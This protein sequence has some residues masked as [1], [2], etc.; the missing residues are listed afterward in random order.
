LEKAT[1]RPSPMARRQSAWGTTGNGADENGAPTILQRAWAIAQRALPRGALILSSLT[2]VNFAVGLLET[3][4]IAHVYGAG[5]ESSA[6][7]A[8]FALPA[9]ILDILVVGGLIASFVPL[10]VG[11]R[12]EEERLA[13][14]FARTILTLALLV[15]AALVAVMIVFAPE[16]VSITAPGFNG[17]QRDLTINLF[18]LLAGTQILMAAV[19]VLGEIL[20]AEKR[21]LSYAVAPITYS[22]GIIVGALLLG[23]DGQLGI[24]GAA[25]GAFGG[26]L[27]YAAIR[28]GGVL[29]AGVVPWPRLS[30]RTRGLRQY[31]VL[32]GPKMV[33]QPLEGTL[34]TFYFT[35]L[36]SQLAT[37]AV[38]NLTFARKFQTAPELIIGA[39]FAIAAFPAL[40]AAA[41]AGDW[42]GF[43][44][45]FG[46][47][48]ATI[49]VL[50]TGAALSLLAL[51]WLAV[52]I[53]LSGGA[54]TAQDVATTTMLV[55]I[56]A[57]SI[58]LESVV[59]LL[60]RAIYAT[61][62]TFLPMVASWV[63]FI[64]LVLTAQ[65]LAP[66]AGLAAIPAAYGVGMGVRVLILA[67]ALAPR[68][69]AIGRPRMVYHP[70][71]V[72]PVGEG[73]ETAWSRP[74]SPVRP[75]PVQ[76]RPA[77]YDRRR[78]PR[79]AAA[80][81][82][83]AILLVGGAYATGQAI[84]GAS[85]FAPVTTPWAR[86]RPPAAVVTSA[87][88]S[89][90]AP[91]TWA[92]TIAPVGG[93]TPTPSPP[94]QFAM[95]LYQPGDFVGE[96]TNTWCMA[97]AM[98]TMMNIMDAG[99]DTS[100]DTQAKL[101]SLAVSIAENRGGGPL[102]Q[103]W[104]TGL[105]QLGYGKYQVAVQNRM[106]GA[107]KQAV[108]QIRLTNRP[109]GLLVWY[110]WHS[111]VVSGFVATADPAV[112]NQ[113]SVISLSIEDVWYNR[114]SKLWNKDRNG[115]SRPPD[116]EVPYGELAVDFKKWDQAVVYPDYQNRY[117]I[118]VPVK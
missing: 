39:Q 104:A 32:M 37:G 107:V 106:D 30:L 27:A 36:A 73:A 40:S 26:A 45:V 18:R 7:Y 99:A 108:T 112:T 85:F 13:H 116:S 31:L 103:G 19:W 47:N 63:A 5:T 42:R 111:W 9:L 109:A 29:R 80:V 44:R 55:A 69:D 117:V 89:P 23:G 21:W 100:Q 110:G 95:D 91:P 38:A 97:A 52:R 70:A 61:R 87:P 90:T 94:G 86:V 54:Y 2:F 6:F 1:R 102:P 84:Q 24:Y 82:G 105:E 79:V 16:C 15:I 25:V 11:L 22:A 115:Y 20:I 64:C 17:A 74:F 62:N 3:K 28:L 96:Y 4:V 14:E 43:R 41:D 50:S 49:A 60:A 8:A 83:V 93:P 92:G 118:I 98:Q 33:S 72:G 114:Q 75:R 46:T 35:F 76:F 51:G 58:P 34:I 67:I 66:L 65:Y 48:L 57:V 101:D 78:A 77:G 71:Q 81:A 59:E 12:D 53:L 113:F 10:Y 68:M 88:P 56:F